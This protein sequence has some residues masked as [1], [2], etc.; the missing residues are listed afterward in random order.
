MGGPGF[1]PDACLALRRR[2]SRDGAG[3]GGQRGVRDKI[4]AIADEGERAAY[5]EQQRKAYEVDID[6]LRLAGE[7][8]VDAI[9]E[10]GDLRR[11]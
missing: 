6:I 8:V 3:G 10:P 9:V 4:A 11:S 2:R 5:V 1:G 7:L